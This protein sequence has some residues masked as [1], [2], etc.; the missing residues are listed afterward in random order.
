[1][2]NNETARRT[3][4]TPSEIRSVSCLLAFAAVLSAATPAKFAEHTIASDLTSGYQVVAIDIDRDG[5]SDLVAL[6]SRMTELVWFE[7]P[8]WARRV[9]S[10]GRNRMINLAA[11]AEGAEG[12]PVIVMAEKFE[13]DVSKSI[14]T[15][16]V[17][18]REGEV[19]RPWKATE[20]DRLPT[21]HR[22]RC[23]DFDGSGEKVF[24]NAPLSGAK[25]RP[26][27]YHDHVPLVYY[28]PGEWKR[29]LIGDENEGV[30]HGIFVIDFDAD[31]ADEILTASFSGIHL[32]GRDGSGWSRSKIAGGDPAPWPKSGASDLAVGQ[33]GGRRFITSIEPWHGNQLVV[34]R[35][36]DDGWN[37]SV[38][39][40]TYADRH[41]VITADLNA[42]GSDEIIAGHRGNGGGVYIYWSGEGERWSRTPLGSKDITVAS[43]AV[44]ELNGDQRPDIACIGSATANLKWYENLGN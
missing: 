18:E 42:D 4:I 24:L 34:Y 19:R 11:C 25:A 33:S 44:A 17:L 43:C 32:Y 31:G 28:R 12:Y 27:D 38:I 26:P 30:M 23:A 2:T 6:A 3:P 40:D 9:L 21:A 15:V 29:H 5:D 14:G 36:K 8:G 1:M 35:Q 39:D 7:N 22:I 41:T 20:I 37:R 10:T 13:S 16:F